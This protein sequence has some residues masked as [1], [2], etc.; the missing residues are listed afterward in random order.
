MHAVVRLALLSTSLPI[1]ALP[2]C[3]RPTVPASGKAAVAAADAG[4]GPDG[5]RAQLADGSDGRDWPAFGRTY[6]EQHYSPLTQVNRDT[7]KRLGLVWSLDLP[8][9][10]PAT[11]PVEVG[12]VVYLASGYSVIRAIDVRTGK[13]LWT[14]D[15]KAPEAAGHKLRQGWGSRGIAYWNGKLYTGTQDGRLIA[16]DAKTGK[17]VWSAMTVG[18]D[19]GRFISG[20][21]RVF[22]GMVIIG[23]GGGDVGPVLRGYVTAYDAETGK[24]AWRFHTVPGN[25]AD[26][27]ENDAMRMAAKTWSGEWWKYGGGGTVWNAITYDGESKTIFLGTGNGFPWNRKIRSAGKG[28]NLFLCSI[29]ALDARTGRY[30]WHYQINPGESWDFNAAMD[31]ELA[32]L[33][34][35]GK[36]RKVLMTAPKNGFFYVIDRTDGKLISAKPFVATSWAKRIDLKTGRPVEE[37]NIRYE[38]G[39]VTFR[40]TPVGAH[41]WPPMAYSPQS[42]LAYIPAIDMQV[43]YDDRGIDRKNW[44]PA[45]GMAL[46]YGVRIAVGKARPSDTTGYLVAWNPVTQKEAWR[47]PM[48]AHFNGGLMATAGGLVFQGHPDST[49]TAYDA[50]T[51]RIAWN[52]DA[53]APVVAPPISYSVDGRQYV[54]VISG[55]GTSGG[56]FGP[57]LT[58]FG[59]DYRT[60]ARRVLTFALDGKATLPAKIPYTPRAVDDPDFRRDPAKVAAGGE[61]FDMRCAVCHGGLAIPGGTAPD[62]RTSAIILDADAFASVVHDGVLVPNGMPRFE[63]LTAGQRDD[64]RHYLRSR[65]D[66]LRKGK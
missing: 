35:D 15:P 66:D 44:K 46:N 41:S 56:M 51:G 25:P 8:A 48:S 7:V 1:L 40:P 21:P 30:K 53:K 13:L 4:A 34:I 58:Q 11:G 60:Q 19:D 12:G 65:A 14:Y 43:T 28:D 36:A 22:D 57:L 38:D 32:D 42:G 18:K 52:Y 17:P 37:P 62:L 33:V 20:P 27:F 2:A 26:G 45:E 49:F 47:L 16:V 10:N 39:P 9:G 29:V 24:Q 61:T 55:M 64:L 5:W 50:K 63:E 54:T 6:G 31:M 59:I 23:H 3:S